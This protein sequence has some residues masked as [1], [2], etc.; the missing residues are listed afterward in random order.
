MTAQKIIEEIQAII[1][2]METWRDK[3]N[4]WETTSQHHKAE[5]DEA[6]KIAESAMFESDQLRSR[7]AK[8][9]MELDNYKWRDIETFDNRMFSI[10]SVGIP[11]ATEVV[12]YKGD[13]PEWSRLWMPLP[14][15]PRPKPTNS[16]GS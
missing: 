15:L 1:G 13:I 12:K 16:D 4:Y 9:E 10:M 3:A 14:P 6:R 5:R 7:C 2:E 11:D 8:L